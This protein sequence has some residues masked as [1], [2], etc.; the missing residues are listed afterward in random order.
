[1]GSITANTSTSTIAPMKTISSGCT[2]AASQVRRRSKPRRHARYLGKRASEVRLAAAGGAV[3]HDLNE[4]SRVRRDQECGRPLHPE[5][6]G[7]DE[8]I[9][10]LGLECVPM[11]QVGPRLVVGEA[12]L[13]L[14]DDVRFEKKP[15]KIETQLCNPCLDLRQRKAMLLD[16]KQQV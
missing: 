2:N 3:D 4:L 15:D 9:G 1:M 10:K 11:V 12:L 6:V 8:R 16:V 5:R 14:A 13:V 7:A